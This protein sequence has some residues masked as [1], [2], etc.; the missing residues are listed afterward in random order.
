MTR[1]AGRLGCAVV[2]S[3]A[4]LALAPGPA[5]APPLGLSFVP[6]TAFFREPEL[7]ALSVSPNGDFYAT[8][9]RRSEE[10]EVRVYR[11]STS[12]YETVNELPVHV[13]VWFDW[14]GDTTLVVSTSGRT[15][16]QWSKEV[17]ALGG[18]DGAVIESRRWIPSQGALVDALPSEDGMLLLGRDDAVYRIDVKQLHDR[19]YR[20][21]MLRAANRV[22]ELDEDVGGWITDREGRV[23]GALSFHDG[24]GNEDAARFRLWQRKPGADWEKVLEW[25]LDEDWVLGPLGFSDDGERILAATNRDRDRFALVELDPTTGDTVATLYEHP[26]AELT[27][28][29]YDYSGRLI[30]VRYYE[31]GAHRTHFFEAE[32]GSEREAIARALPGREFVVRSR[33]RNDTVLSFYAWSDTDI[34]GFYLL[35][36]SDE[37]VYSVGRL[38]PWLDD[39]PLGERRRFVVQ[40][41]GG[42][43]VEAFFTEPGRRDP[44]RKPPLVVLPHGGPI[45]VR[46]DGWYDPLVQLLSHFGYAVLQVNYRGSAGFGRAFEEL[47]KGQ[48]GSGIED[49]IDAAFDHVVAQDWIDTSRVVAIGGSYGGYSSLM[50]AVRHPKRFAAVV[51]LFGVTDLPLV[52]DTRTAR[53]SEAMKKWWTET[54]GDREHD[55]DELIRRSPAYRAREFEAP[56]LIIHGAKDWIVDV[57]HAYRLRTML[58]RHDKEYEFTVI[59]DLDHSFGDPKTAGR[60]GDR[61]LGFLEDRLY[62]DDRPRG[63]LE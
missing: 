62:G 49:D 34:G 14:V 12:E 21:G 56:I 57:D 52:F 48:F 19:D 35:D 5:P 13:G 55:Y 30:G 22:A 9:V 11:R 54:I 26:T 3:A 17:I 47:G 23:R 60:L 25:A 59:K 42:P 2:W 41:T 36:T 45:G 32:V 1:R 53:L 37:Q 51:T 33:S 27:G 28:L 8:I 63:E 50:S 46:D 15:D 29:E 44:Y 6:T 7:Q 4:L 31:G 20:A 40:A 58:D 24:D 38:M 39:L 61:V 18:T 10:R 43:E 16:R